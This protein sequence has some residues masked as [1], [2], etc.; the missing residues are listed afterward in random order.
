MS[1]SLR[2]LL[3][4]L[5]HPIE[6]TGGWNM[7]RTQEKYL[8]KNP[9]M[10]AASLSRPLLAADSI[11][12][13]APDLSG[14]RHDETTPADLEWI[15]AS[16]DDQPGSALHAEP[17]DCI[18]KSVEQPSSELSDKPP[19]LDEILQEGPTS[20]GLVS[21][22]AFDYPVP[23]IDIASIE[24]LPDP[25][26]F[27]VPDIGEAAKVEDD[28][29]L[30]PDVSDSTRATQLASA[31][32]RE[33]DESS[34]RN[35]EYI[36]DIIRARRW[37]SVQRKVRELLAVHYSVSAVYLIFEVL[38]AWRHCEWLDQTTEEFGLF[39]STLTWQEAA[40]LVDF[41][42]VGT[43]VAE[44]MDFVEI[45]HHVWRAR[46]H[47]RRSHARFKDYLLKQRIAHESY[48]KDLGWFDCLDPKD[49]RTFDGWN[50][51]EFTSDWWEE[52]LPGPVVH[53][54][55]SRIFKGD[56]LENMIR[57]NGFDSGLEY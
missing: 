44:V 18:P 47:L 27:D 55:P 53:S 21:S 5:L 24:D 20:P 7:A 19:L 37:S 31:F 42:G 15:F 35:I 34:A 17:A 28:T 23:E 26:E 43:D 6:S 57:S 8:F 1:Q 33:F 40:S 45:E 2:Q 22:P 48:S 12:A 36:A 38:E 52:E 25:G 16:L 29:D 49:G 51:V 11:K 30:Q 50:N 10:R 41:F 32:L 13:S 56:S 4:K 39:R 46:S 3:S 54:V 9:R 14:Y